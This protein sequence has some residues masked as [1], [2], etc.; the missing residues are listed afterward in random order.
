MRSR[1]RALVVTSLALFLS[2]LVWFNYSAVLPLIVEE[3]GLSGTRAGIIFG[4]FQAGYLVA[5]LPAG[6]LADRYSPRWVVSVGAAGTGLFSLGFALFATGFLSGTAFRFLSG[7]FIA[8][9]YVPGMRFVSDWYPADVRG[10]AMG[11]YIGTFSL[12]SGLSFV[13]ATVVADAVD[14]RTAIA[15][16]SVG[17]LAV[18]PL[19]LGLAEDSPGR[20]ARSSRGVDRSL[21]KNRAYLACV[22]VYSWHNWELFGVRNWLL[23][24]LLV[25]PAFAA[26]GSSGGAFGVGAATLAGLLVGVVTA[27]S[28]V[29]NVAGGVL[30]DRIGRSRTIGLGLGGS[31]ICSAT[32]GVLGWL[33]LPAL[34]ALLLVYGTLL[35]VDSAP[36][37]TLVTE[38]VDDDQVGTALSIQSF[39]GFSTTV[40]SPVVFGLAL[41]VGG[42]ALAWPTLAAGALAGLASVAVLERSLRRRAS[43][44]D[45]VSP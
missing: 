28:G 13:A 2:I 23:A 6:W 44:V 25:T 15:V 11:L 8:G 7:L 27:M 5:I 39:V 3:W 24:F 37:S 1:T 14:W 30:S 32:L 33:P 35:S 29:G 40:V 19:M 10:R 12:S 42:Y 20:S 4:V 43:R 16:T 34:V 17:A 9:V 22:S 31:A 21:L 41:D 18:P 45:P 26:V 36:T 38:V